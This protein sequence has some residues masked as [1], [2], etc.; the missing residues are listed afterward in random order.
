M[1]SRVDRPRDGNYVLNEGH[2]DEEYVNLDDVVD[3]RCIAAEAHRTHQLI[4]E[5]PKPDIDEDDPEKKFKTRVKDTVD[6]RERHLFM[7]VLLRRLKLFLF[8]QITDVWLHLFFFISLQLSKVDIDSEE[9]DQTERHQEVDKIWEIWCVF[10][11][12]HVSGPI[13]CRII[14]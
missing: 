2:Q 5:V 12:D 9:F 4:C 7:L 14:A 13:A 1:E 8:K 11:L 10:I 3:I 6:D